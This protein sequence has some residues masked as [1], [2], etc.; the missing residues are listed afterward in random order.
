MQQK[1]VV[2][3]QL[4]TNGLALEFWHLI[5]YKYILMLSEQGRLLSLAED[6]TSIP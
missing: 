5:L 6:L 4:T 1:G 2:A 3:I